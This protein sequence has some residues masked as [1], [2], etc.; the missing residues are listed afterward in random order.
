MNMNYGLSPEAEKAREEA[1]GRRR[2]AQSDWERGPTVYDGE[3]SIPS[4]FYK[5]GASE[6]YKRLG[7]RFDGISKRWSRPIAEL[8][9]G[10]RYS[11]QAWL[12]AARKAYKM[13]WPSWEPPTEGGA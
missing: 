8:Y 13:V 12:A 2:S 3:V 9:R 10:K 7:F 1:A 5:P 4:E 11:A 6:V